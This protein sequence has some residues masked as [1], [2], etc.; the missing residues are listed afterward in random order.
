VPLS[1][2]IEALSAA[3]EA[4]RR[5]VVPFWHFVGPFS[6]TKRHVS[7]FHGPMQGQE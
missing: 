4:P 1:L 3:E 5:R 2:E 6:A 7:P